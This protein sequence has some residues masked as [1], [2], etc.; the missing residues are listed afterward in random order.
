[1]RLRTIWLKSE[2]PLCILYP[3]FNFLCFPENLTTCRASIY[4]EGKRGQE[5]YPLLH[6]GDSF[7]KIVIVND[8]LQPRTFDNDG[9]GYMGLVD[10]LLDPN[11]L[12]FR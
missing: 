2:M 7:R 11:A 3:V 6:S 10:F 12:D 9:I 1:M 8:P 4:D 5:T